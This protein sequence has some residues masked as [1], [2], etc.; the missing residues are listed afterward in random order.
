MKTTWKTW[1]AVMMAAVGMLPLGCSGSVV[2][3]PAQPNGC[4]ATAPTAVSE[5]NVAPAECSYASGPCT[6]KL[7]C[8]LD[9]GAWQLQSTTCTPMATDCLSAQEGDSCEV[10][11]DSCATNGCDGDHSATCGDDHHWHLAAI[12]STGDNCCFHDGACPIVLPNDGE[13]CDLCHG[14][15]ACA[16]PSA[17]GEDHAFCGD[18]GKWHVPIG[19]CPPPPP[20]DFCTSNVDQGACEMDASCRWL[21]PG[22][23]DIPLWAPGCFT[24]S[25]CG[26][27]NCGPS[28]ICQT[29]SYNPCFNKGCDACGAPASL[30][31]GGL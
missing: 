3:G 15:T 8:D 4:P 20:P 5:C 10:V 25:D 23:G 24:I 6:V 16:Y 27:G 29:F 28:Q 13:T 9:L 22:C 31:V 17:C 18:D 14:A 2:G 7:R 11:G 30:C 21:T 19:E 26:P 1:A 12:S